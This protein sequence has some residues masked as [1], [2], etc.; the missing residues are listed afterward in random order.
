MKHSRQSL[1]FTLIEL[2]VVISIIA[3]LASL[4]LPALTR[5]RGAARQTECKSNLKQFS[6]ALVMYT[7]ENDGYKPPAYMNPTNGWNTYNNWPEFLFPYMGVS[8]PNHWKRS[9]WAL[10][11]PEVAGQPINPADNIYS[12]ARNSQLF[13]NFYFTKYDQNIYGDAIENTSLA[14]TFMDAIKEAVGPGGG[15]EYN[16]WYRH[17]E[18]YANTAYLDG[19]VDHFADPYFASFGSGYWDKA[20]SAYNPTWARFWGWP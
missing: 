15:G 9:T 1:S 2:L 14:S 4:L 13:R 3:M 10:P 18:T 11:C 20:N 8:T 5:A 19:H 17:N 6:T 7:D 12:Y 16:I